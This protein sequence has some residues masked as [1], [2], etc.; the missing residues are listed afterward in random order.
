MTMDDGEFRRL[1]RQELGTDRVSGASPLARMAL[2]SLAEYAGV[3]TADEP[4]TLRKELLSFAEELQY[5]RPSMAPVFNLVQR[6]MDLI[7]ALPASDA[8]ALRRSAAQAADTL[9]N[10][11]IE[12]VKGAAAKAAKRIGADQ[13]VITHSLSSTVQ[14][15]FEALASAGVRAIVTESRPGFEG[16]NQARHLDQLGIPVTFITD[17]QLGHFV[18]E[19]DLALVGADTVLADGAVVNKAGTYLLALAARDRGVPLLVCCESFKH[20]PFRAKEFDLEEMDVREVDAPKGKRIT[21]RN[22]YFDIT[23]ARLI[24][25]WVTEKSIKEKEKQKTNTDKHR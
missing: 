3:C 9:A 4:G 24:D 8:A 19:A 20:A 16:R 13:L 11:S 18:A 14:A 22:V 25:A 6:W 15:T 10:E 21:A 17:A 12:A 23:P 2:D 1:R 5:T 7:D